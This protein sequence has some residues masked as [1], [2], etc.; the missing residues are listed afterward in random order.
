MAPLMAHLAE[1]NANGSTGELFLTELAGL[2]GAA[3]NVWSPSRQRG[4]RSASANTIAELVALDTA[5]R[6]ATAEKLM[7]A[8]V[9]IFGRY[10][11]ITQRSRLRRT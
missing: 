8:G 7:A 3:V 5:L 10:R 1:L 2:L 4:G 9:T 11:V 6:A